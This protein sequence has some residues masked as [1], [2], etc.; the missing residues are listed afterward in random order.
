M[1]G[2]EEAH[3]GFQKAPKV[4]PGTEHTG[5][6]MLECSLPEHARQDETMSVT[7]VPDEPVKHELGEEAAG[8]DGLQQPY[9]GGVP[10]PSSA[11]RGEIIMTPA[12][13]KQQKLQKGY[14]LVPVVVDPAA[15][16]PSLTGKR[17]RKTS[18]HFGNFHK[19]KLYWCCTHLTNN[20]VAGWSRRT[21][22]WPLRACT[23]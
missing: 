6:H 15:L 2:A 4:E 17:E 21:G 22:S 9:L 16:P 10:Q 23:A 5:E 20:L 3:A 18:K 14:S 13:A 1:S 7:T 8:C 12:E 19:S 11:S